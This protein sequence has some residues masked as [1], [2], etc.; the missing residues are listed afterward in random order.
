MQL[1][2]YKPSESVLTQDIGADMSRPFDFAQTPVASAK[3]FKWLRHIPFGRWIKECKLI[4]L[5]DTAKRND[6]H[7]VG[8]KKNIRVTTVIN[9]LQMFRLHHDMLVNINLQG[10]VSWL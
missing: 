9:V 1:L 10:Q 3:T 5:F 2:L 6:L 7:C 4:A 8:V